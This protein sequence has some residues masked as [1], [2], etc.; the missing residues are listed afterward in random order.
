MIENAIYA[1]PN[2]P[3]VISTWSANS[4]LPVGMGAAASVAWGTA[5][6]AIYVPFRIG[7]PLL[8]DRLFVVCG[9]TQG[10]GNTISIAIYDKDF[11]R[12]VTT[13]SQTYNGGTNVTNSFDVTDTRIGPGLFYFATALSSTTDTV[14]ANGSV[15]IL[16]RPLGIAQETTA[17]PLPE[18]GTPAAAASNILPLIGLSGRTTV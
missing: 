3:T 9:A 13:G 16:L 15:A 6:R 18:V 7:R 14:M 1:N 10:G 11:T 17:H 2:A 8:V 4:V 12:L 5:N